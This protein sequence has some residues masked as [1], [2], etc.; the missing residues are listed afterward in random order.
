MIAVGVP[1]RPGIGQLYR[2]CYTYGPHFD[3]SGD[4]EE[5][6]KICEVD[7]RLNRGDMERDMY[8]LFH[9]KSK[10]IREWVTPAALEFMEYIVVMH[11][12]PIISNH[13]FIIDRIE[14]LFV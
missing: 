14:P 1:I 2:V 5:F 13:Y 9:Q 4:I 8:G 12:S 3:G 7:D 10:L 11:R 6:E